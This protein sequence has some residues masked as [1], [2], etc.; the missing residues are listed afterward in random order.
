[1]R[2]IRIGPSPDVFRRI[3]RPGHEGTTKDAAEALPDSS[4]GVSLKGF[5]QSLFFEISEFIL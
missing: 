4:T 3:P 1:M 2:A 5:L